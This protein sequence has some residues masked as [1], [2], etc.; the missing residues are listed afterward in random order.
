MR[1]RLVAALSLLA[2]ATSVVVAPGS[3]AAGRLPA[4]ASTAPGRYLVLAT[5]G[6]HLVDARAAAVAAGGVVVDEDADLAALVVRSSAAG[7]AATVRSAPGVDG[8]AA[9]AAIGRI[10]TGGG[11]GKSWEGGSA[12]VGVTGKRA[13]E[14]TGGPGTSPEPLAGDQWDMDQIR[15]TANGT[16]VVP[17]GDRRV[18]LAIVDSGIDVTHP[19]LAGSVDTRL[20]RSFVTFDPTID[21][22]CSVACDA[23]VGVD[24]F[25]HGTAMASLASAKVNGFGMAGVAPG[26]TLVDLRVGQPTGWVLATPVVQALMYA[27]RNGID[28]ASL[29]FSIDPWLFNCRSNPADSTDEQAQQRTIIKAVSRATRFARAHDVTLVAAAGNENLNLDDPGTDIFSPDIPVSGDL[30]RERTITPGDC[31]YLPAMAPGVVTVAGT[32]QTRAKANISNWG[33]SIDLA[34]PSSARNNGTAP[35]VQ[36][37]SREGAINNGWLDPSTGEITGPIAQECRDKCGYYLYIGGTS[38]A[39][40]EVAGVAALVVSEHVRRTGRRGMEPAAVEA[41]LYAT[42]QATPCPATDPTYPELPPFLSST[43]HCVATPAGT[44]FAGR[45][46]VDAAAAAR[47]AR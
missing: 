30:T 35:I 13:A 4:V 8:V 16:R 47:A 2:T 44:S 15:V 6:A 46:I 17:L 28:V 32:D 23:P 40:A 22:A 1:T 34:A 38:D 41:A 31:L 25:G 14:R 19:D 42:A 12:G 33:A 11:R 18:R 43:A 29:S 39:A 9:D 3:S 45:G 24:P 27:A 5:D 10:A 36:A 7:F 26:V 20:S 21:P 37:I